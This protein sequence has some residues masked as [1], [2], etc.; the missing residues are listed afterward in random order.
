MKKSTEKSS[1]KNNFGYSRFRQIFPFVH[2]KIQSQLIQCERTSYPGS[3]A[4][5]DPT[6]PFCPGPL[7]PG[8]FFIGSAAPISANTPPSLKGISSLTRKSGGSVRSLQ[9]PF[10]KN[11]DCG[12]AHGRDCRACSNVRSF[13]EDMLTPLSMN[14]RKLKTLSTIFLHR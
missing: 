4:A 2:A 10:R 1:W 7:R 14:S 8:S 11:Q 13:S 5:A 6:I 3:H 9:R 12:K